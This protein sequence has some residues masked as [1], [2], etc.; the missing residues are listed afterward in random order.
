MFT[1]S[2]LFKV[3][4]QDDQIGVDVAIPFKMAI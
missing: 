4:F 2:R 1:A 3:G